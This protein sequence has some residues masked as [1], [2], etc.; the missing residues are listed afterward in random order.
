MA[1]QLKQEKV[2]PLSEEDEE[3]VWEVIHSRM[4]GDDRA[5]NEV[6]LDRYGGDRNR[7][8]RAMAVYHGVQI[9]S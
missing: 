4:T 2:E 7:Y 9:N 8:W 5:P 6:I 3:R 1:E